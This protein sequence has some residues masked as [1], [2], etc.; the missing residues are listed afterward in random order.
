MNILHKHK[1]V[2]QERFYASPN[3]NLQ[4]VRV[5]SAKLLKE[6]TFGVTTILYRCE[7]CNEIKIIEILGKAMK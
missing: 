5:P 4:E 6:L 1:W 3:S 2:E 7:D